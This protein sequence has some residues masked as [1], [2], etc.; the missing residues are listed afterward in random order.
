MFRWVFFV[1][2]LLF[3]VLSSGFCFFCD[4]CVFFRIFIYSVEVCI[5]F[6]VCVGVKRGVV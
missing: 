3:E 5:F 1:S 4:L 2:F 6:G